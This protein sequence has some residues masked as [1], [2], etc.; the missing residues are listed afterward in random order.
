MLKSSC[1]EGEAVK[2]VPGLLREPSENGD[3]G[4]FFCGMHRASKIVKRITRTPK[5]I[6]KMTA[7]EIDAAE[8]CSQIS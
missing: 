2:L 5:A 8:H 6:P 3:G 1:H 4:E 7:F